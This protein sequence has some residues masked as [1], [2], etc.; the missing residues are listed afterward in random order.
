MLSIGKVINAKDGENVLPIFKFVGN[1][2]FVI[3]SDVFDLQ[4]RLK[5]ITQDKG[6]TKKNL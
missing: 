1:Q 5:A 3:S 4:D 6:K 2:H